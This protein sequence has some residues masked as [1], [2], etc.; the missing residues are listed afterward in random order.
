M[1]SEL[2]VMKND[3]GAFYLGRTEWDDEIHYDAPYSRQSGYFRSEQEAILALSCYPANRRDCMENH[4]LYDQEDQMKD[5]K[6]AFEVK[7]PYGFEM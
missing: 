3:N 2:K 5:P 1:V 6:S 7:Y 4:L